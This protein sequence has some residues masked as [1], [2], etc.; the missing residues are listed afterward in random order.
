MTF[1]QI[2]FD[3]SSIPSYNSASRHH[4]ITFSNDRYGFVIAG[5][6][7][8][9]EYLK[10]VHRYDAI[11]NTWQQLADFP[12]GPRGFGY[13]VAKNNK[14]YLGFG[15]NDDFYP[16]DW[17]EYDM[18]NDSWTQLADFPYAS[19]RLHPAMVLVNQSVYVGLGSDLYG[20]LG[21]WWE[22]KIDQ[23]QWV[24]RADFLFGDRHHPFY[25]GIGDFPYVGFG[26]GNTI[27]NGF[28]I[29]NDFYKYDPFTDEW[30][31]MSELPAEGRVA[32]T[33]FSYNGKGYAL[34]GDGDDH[35]TLDS[36][37][38][39]EYDPQNDSWLQLDSHPGNSR[40]APGCFVI[41]C[42]V[43]FTSGLDR[44]SGTYYNDMLM[45]QLGDACG[46]LDSN[47]INY[48]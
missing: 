39:W 1:A 45:A 13:G 15:K 5:Q 23:N 33:Q 48:N 22:Y 46:C 28:N 21:D 41:N 4:P 26:H 36:G 19:G 47:A 9:Y 31:T 27:G 20:N 18:E 10:D 11:T 7:G 24:Q 34:S 32:G 40:W 43:Y 29:Y 25:F 37:E 38:L 8:S 12:G 42:N 3:W 2:N 6:T 16:N 44:Q 35:S 17:W 30:I 14:A